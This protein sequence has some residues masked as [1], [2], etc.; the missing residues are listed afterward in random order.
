MQKFITIAILALIIT[1]IITTLNIFNLPQNPA[2]TTPPKPFNVSHKIIAT[3]GIVGCLSEKSLQQITKF[4]LKK[5][6]A[7]MQSMVNQGLCVY[8]LNG[9]ELL[10]RED[11]CLKEKNIEGKNIFVSIPKKMTSEFYLPCSAIF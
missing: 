2:E 5:N 9:S 10:T 11:A 4:Y 8:F 6:S 1:P 3:P 7:A